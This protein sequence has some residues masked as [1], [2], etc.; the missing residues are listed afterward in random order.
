VLAQEPLSDFGEGW[1]FVVFCS[2]LFSLLALG[3]RIFAGSDA[4]K[5]GLRRKPGLLRCEITMAADFDKPSPTVPTLALDPISHD[6]CLRAA[7]FNLNAKAAQITVP[8]PLTLS[9]WIGLIDDAFS[10]F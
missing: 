3:G 6:V 8:E 10:E 1:R 5:D 2:V 9:A 4:T 7:L